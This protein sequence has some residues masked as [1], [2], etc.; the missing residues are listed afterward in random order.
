MVFP[1]FEEKKLTLERVKS[2]IEVSL[3]NLEYAE[4]FDADVAA[5]A[6]FNQLSGN[7]SWDDV[8]EKFE[9]QLSD[10]KGP[11][12]IEEGDD[13]YAIINDLAEDVEQELLCVDAEEYG[14]CVNETAAKNLIKHT[15]PEVIERRPR[16][17]VLYEASQCIDENMALRAILD[18]VLVT[19]VGGTDAF[20]KRYGDDCFFKEA[21]IIAVLEADKAA[22]EDPMSSAEFDAKSV[23]ELV[24]ILEERGY[25]VESRES[26]QD[27]VIDS[28]KDGNLVLA[29]HVLSALADDHQDCPYFIYDKSMGEMETPVPVKYHEDW[30]SYFE[31][32]KN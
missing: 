17:P 29:H 9:R 15:I 27:F 5:E 6:V 12:V 8:L 2:I 25:S 13:I 20:Q 18:A 21:D 11:D 26:L 7:A 1:K 23:D 3:D 28:V 4:S 10:G 24:K 30:V 22:S 14:R 31:I 19:V 16:Y 32:Q